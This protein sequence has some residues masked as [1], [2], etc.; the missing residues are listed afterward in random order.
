MSEQAANQVRGSRGEGEKLADFANLVFSM[1]HRPHN[2]EVLMPKVYGE[3]RDSESW[4]YTMRE[5][6]EIRAMVMAMPQPVTSPNHFP[7]L[8]FER[9]G[10]G[11]VSVHHRARG[12]GYMQ[13]L[14]RTAIADMVDR[15][16]AY[17]FLSGQRQRYRYYGYD[18]A[19]ILMHYSLSQRNLI[20][21][22]PALRAAQ[23]PADLALIKLPTS[24]PLLDDAYVL[25]QANE[26]LQAR[27]KEDFTLICR[28]FSQSARA[29]VR[30]SAG[31]QDLLA[32][33][34]VDNS[35]TTISELARTEAAPAWPELLLRTMQL[36]N[37]EKI[38]LQLP[39]A[40]GGSA[41]ELQETLGFVS[42]DCS[43]RNSGMFL[44]L[45]FAKT[46]GMLLAAKAT[47]VPLAPGRLRLLILECPSPAPAEQTVEIRVG[48][49]RLHVG[50]GERLFVDADLPLTVD[51][52]A[53][54]AGSTEVALTYTDA[55]AWLFSPRALLDNPLRRALPVAEASWLPLNP[56]VSTAD[57]C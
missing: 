16:S 31:G 30:R 28:T 39:L 53:V 19:G 1:D 25:Y 41:L 9:V 15:G 51:E 6:G 50:N 52:L 48:G 54:E 13:Q 42:E 34:V 10:I 23:L 8:A 26:G 46:I 35:N 44:I 17:S 21:T 2:F 32:Y 24:G 3:G 22:W 57:N 36:L 29:L 38:S 5:D 7:D 47:Q 55:L 43:I 27:A 37:Q 14:M 45:D 40:F 11:N 20:M 12:K 33:Y 56:F 18:N 49:G 4:H